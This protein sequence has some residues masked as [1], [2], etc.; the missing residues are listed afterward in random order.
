MAADLIS[1]G[2]GPFVV[3]DTYTPTPDN[4][5][6]YE[7]DGNG[8][9]RRVKVQ[10]TNTQD[11]YAVQGVS[12]GSQLDL[13]G[14]AIPAGAPIITFYDATGAVIN[15]KNCT[16]IFGFIATADADFTDTAG[17]AVLAG[18]QYLQLPSGTACLEKTI[19]TV[20]G[21]SVLGFSDGSQ[22]DQNGDPIPAGNEIITTIDAQGNV[23][24]HA[25]VQD[26]DTFGVATN[27][28]AGANDAWG[29]PIAT[30][31]NVIELANGDFV[32]VPDKFTRDEF[33]QRE[34]VED[35]EPPED[36]V[37]DRNGNEISRTP[38]QETVKTLCL[39][40]GGRFHSDG[41]N[42][43]DGGFS[44]VPMDVYDGSSV[45]SGVALCDLSVHMHSVTSVTS[46]DGGSPEGRFSLEPQVKV[47]GVQQP[48]RLGAQNDL[49]FYGDREPWNSEREVHSHFCLTIPKGA[50]VISGCMEIGAVTGIVEGVFDES[51]GVAT[52]NN[53]ALVEFPDQL[54][55]Y[56]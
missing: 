13:D 15:S 17:N 30:G 7:Y 52:A 5:C 54:V 14:N 32:C 8:C 36:V 43:G 1:F 4:G 9:F 16:D 24:A 25:D 34:H 41:T 6:T 56:S 28:P 2:D 18:D 21:Y 55:C 38:V 11:G 31:A 19:D 20:D 50:F 26:D 12:D 45:I 40:S 47:N 42:V 29:N 10:D 3:G 35:C 22:L 23:V 44:P 48:V 27:A 53:Q 33:H 51:N 46:Y 37:C 39:R 49:N